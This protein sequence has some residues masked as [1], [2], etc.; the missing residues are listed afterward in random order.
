[1]I[2]KLRP[3]VAV[4]EKEKEIEFFL[5]NTRKSLIIEGEG[6]E[7]KNLI[8]K[9]DGKL[10]VEEVL[11]SL[12]V[13][14]GTEEYIEALELLKFLNEKNILIN[15]DCEYIEEYYKFPRVFGILEDY[16]LSYS[17]VNQ[18]FNK[19]KNSKV[20]ITGMGAVGTWVAHN[21]VMSGVKN[22]V[23]VD[24]DEV[25]LSNLHRQ[26][27]F[28]EKNIGKSKI[29]SIKNRL[30][31]MNQEIKIEEINDILDND[32]FSRN[33]INNVNLIINCADKPS[34]DVTSSII[35]EYCMGKNIKHIIGGGYNLH[36]TLIGQVIIPGESACINC[37]KKSLEEMNDIETS[38][39]KK[40]TI[41]N[42]KVGS[43][44]P[45][46]SLTAS[47]TSNEAIKVLA[48][49]DKMVMTNKR[50]E[51]LL[52]NMNFK[53]IKMTRR[54]DCEWCGEKGKYYKI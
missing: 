52:E 37:F 6:Q 8:F 2:Y 45:L 39:L 36:L 9:F 50:S 51:F 26:L 11:S 54:K 53:N 33:Q 15:I 19:L 40:L 34:V 31:E 27:G 7:I 22:F 18:K 16:S 1:M 49:I 29:E 20:M 5:T 35:G 48:G 44:P 23:L 43:F 42:R 24:N 28:F 14:L 10:S 41:K 32:F 38:N 12:N 47:I 17:E 21:L 30:L 25:E 4:V 46:S 3:S 13:I